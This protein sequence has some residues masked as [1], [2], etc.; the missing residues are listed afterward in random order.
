[1]Q[2]SKIQRQK[3]LIK[4]HNCQR[5]TLKENYAL[6]FD[7]KIHKTNDHSEHLQ[8]KFF[9]TKTPQLRKLINR[10]WGQIHCSIKEVI[11]ML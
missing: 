8:N 11:L 10:K 7:L 1:M 6:K 5:P 4:V 9:T 2:E 3:L